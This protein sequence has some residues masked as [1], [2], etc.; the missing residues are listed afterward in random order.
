MNAPPVRIVSSGGLCRAARVAI[1]S[2]ALTPIVVL[3]AGGAVAPFA[4]AQNAPLASA[5]AAAPVPDQPI[6]VAK[7]AAVG[8]TGGDQTAPVVMSPFEV[9][10]SHDNG[11]AASSSFSGGRLATPL[12]DTAAPYQVLD[13]EM[14]EALG[15]HEIRDALDWSTNS[16]IG[17]DGSGGG[18]YYNLPVLNSTR[19]GGGPDTFRQ[20]NFFQYF[21]PN[22]SFDVERYDI[23]RGPNAVLFGLGG[24]Q[25]TSITQFKVAQTDQA[26]QSV[27][28]MTGSYAHYRASFDVNQPTA[29]NKVAVRL[30]GVYDSS[31]GWRMN[32]LK[33]TEA[34]YAAI[35][36]KPFKNTEIRSSFEKGQQNVLQSYITLNDNFGGWDGKTVFSAGPNFA[37]SVTGVASAGGT[38]LTNGG[39][40]QGVQ[41][42]GSNYFLYDRLSGQNAIMNYYDMFTTLGAGATLTTP[43]Y[44]ATAPS[45]NYTYNH[46]GNVSFA[47]SGQPII[48]SFDIPGD[49][50]ATAAANSAWRM[51]SQQFDNA[52]HTPNQLIHYDYIDLS[53]DQQVGDSLF[54]QL[55][56]CVNYT[57]NVNNQLQAGTQNTYLDINKTLPNGSPDPHFLQPYADTTYSWQYHHRNNDGVRASVAY[58]HDFGNWG[59]YQVNMMV[60]DN[61]TYICGRGNVLSVEQ[62]A[63]PRQWS[64]SDT[65]R[66]RTYWYD[67]RSYA[68]PS[69]PI[70]YVNPQT[71]V[72]QT[73]T[74]H[75]V[76]QAY[77]ASPADTIQHDAFGL[78]ALNAKYFKGRLVIQLALR[79]DITSVYTRNA[80]NEGQYPATWNGSQIIWRPDAP[81]DWNTLTYYPKNASGVITGPLQAAVSRPV[82]GN[83]LGVNIPAPQYANDR[84][85][86]DYNP[87]KLNTSK[88]IT[89]S[90]A[91]VLHI[92][93]WWSVM[94][95]M[96]S[97]FT[98]NSSTTPQIDGTNLPNVLAHGFDIGTRFS[99][100]DGRLSIGYNHYWNYSTGNHT[101][102]NTLT[103]PIISLLGYR[104]IG[105]TSSSGTNAL[106]L[107]LLVGGANDTADQNALGDEIEVTANLAPG[108]RV[109]GNW[110]L[111]FLYGL[112]ADPLLLKYCANNQQN[113]VTILQQDGGALDTTVHP[114][115]A[116]GSAYV[117][118][119]PA[120]TVALDQTAAVNAYNNIYA[121]KAS[122]VSGKQI[123]FFPVTLNFFTDYTIQT[124]MFKGLT[125]GI[126]D[127]YRGKNVVGYTAGNT[128]PN[129]A[130]PGTAIPDPTASAYTPIKV[131]GY[132][133]VTGTIGYHWDYRGRSV[134]VN[135]R[136]INL[137]NERQIIYNNA[138]THFAPYGGDY[139]SAA[140]TQYPNIFGLFRAPM[141][142]ELEATIKL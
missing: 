139:T 57:D 75:W 22:D 44:T 69:G 84:F 142:F 92:T 93:P 38:T 11:F 1:L 102:P 119:L 56:G 19:G 13:K 68:P 24:L 16:F 61:E 59:S 63:D 15:I 116:P 36:Y 97:T 27:D 137:L 78:L 58:Q 118:T 67:D 71:G 136:L 79:D 23:G 99:L 76:T 133:T 18:Y 30:D 34:G 52:V 17:L 94:G 3:V 40:D 26:F 108:W 66:T 100:F 95:D 83:G 45:G 85:Q 130:S 128:I 72:S 88:G 8:N 41:R 51:P 55:A 96:S 122:I 42:L 73:I 98:P 48:G 138:G 65:V 64:V 6:P 114:N 123:N 49:R 126:G 109:T 35:T 125:L 10:T 70:L 32:D 134:F 132:N 82:V 81:A 91:S 103:S 106:G 120:G 124:G 25:A 115:G 46:A 140:R 37:S 9:D 47:S 28:V 12:A 89:K 113:F 131:A 4:L 117:A 53:I 80:L 86:D 62:N 112:N 121:A 77:A 141:N 43:L 2:R 31:S 33:L 14:I 74:P 7:T 111:P 5:A 54:F 110:S 50:F 60:S 21:A 90:F 104:P 87:P 101:V 29:N 127:Q 107:P 20:T 39:N 105:V 129:P 135:L